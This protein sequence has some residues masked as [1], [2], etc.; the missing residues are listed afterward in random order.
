MN[1]DFPTEA[2]LEDMVPAHLIKGAGQ[3]Y[4]TT[5]HT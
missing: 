2:Y 4:Q 3:H 5:L 1:L